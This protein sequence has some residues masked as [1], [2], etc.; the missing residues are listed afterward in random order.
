MKSVKL[1]DGQ[2][3]LFEEE[4]SSLKHEKPRQYEN[5]RIKDDDIILILYNSGKLVYEDNLNTN[6]IL[7][8]VLKCSSENR[9]NSNGK[10]HKNRKIRYYRKSDIE[11]NE[12]T[13]NN[14]DEIL[15]NYDYTIGSD[16]AGKGEWY[17]PLVVTATATSSEDNFKLREIGVKDSKKLN[18][19]QIE[20]L[21]HKIKKLEIKEE[22]II[23]NPSNYNKLYN[24]FRNENKNLNHLLA[25]L[26]SKCIKS[27][28][29][30]INSQNHLV[31][32]DKFDTKKMNEYLNTNTKNIIQESNAEKYTPVAT[33][34]I[35]AKYEYEKTL[36]QLEERYNINLSKKT[37]P[38]MIDKKI[39]TKVAKTHF[40]NISRYL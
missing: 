6:E 29:T 40:K 32:I 25:Y 5:T 34:S 21:Y 8:H 23:L 3:R 10:K 31:I 30:Q 19:N 12:T 13:F 26:H 37:K 4:T 15:T 35:I 7:N 22:T 39:L 20:K 36:N 33:S 11:N 9:T 38:K 28:Q 2:I 16:E 17:G 18:K 1:N 27:L 14:N 24:K